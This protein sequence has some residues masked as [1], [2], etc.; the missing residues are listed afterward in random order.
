MI[1][2]TSTKSTPFETCLKVI[3]KLEREKI[4]LKKELEELRPIK[5][6]A[7]RKLSSAKL[8]RGNFIK[9]Q[10]GLDE[11]SAQYKDYQEQ[12]EKLDEKIKLLEEILGILG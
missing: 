6:R 9:H 8:A 10:K 4:E 11:N 3:D 5:E 1:I 7:G 2:E 12:I